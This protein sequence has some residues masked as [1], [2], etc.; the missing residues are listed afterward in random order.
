[1]IS[2]CIKNP[3][4]EVKF[5]YGSF[6]A[7]LVFSFNVLFSDLPPLFWIA[8]LSLAMSRARMLWA[9]FLKL[10]LLRSNTEFFLFCSDIN[11]SMC[12]VQYAS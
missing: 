10:V 5:E 8:A 11:L 6:P 7:L 2:D 1:M 9:L 4:C 12:Q 3:V